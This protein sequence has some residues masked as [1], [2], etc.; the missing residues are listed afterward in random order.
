ML[1]ALERDDT[2]IV[3]LYN[4]LYTINQVTRFSFNSPE[5][6]GGEEKYMCQFHNIFTGAI[7]TYNTPITLDKTINDIKYCM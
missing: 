6:I 3:T 5:D 2:A 4:I 1:D 7:V